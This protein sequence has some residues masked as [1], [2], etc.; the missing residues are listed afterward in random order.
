MINELHQSIPTMTITIWQGE[1]QLG[2]DRQV[3]SELPKAFKPKDQ[4]KAN[5]DVEEAL[6]VLTPQTRE[7]ICEAVHQST[8]DKTN[9]IFQQ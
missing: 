5:R 3:N 6:E 1:E 7:Y 2:Q 9:K 4:A 8:Q